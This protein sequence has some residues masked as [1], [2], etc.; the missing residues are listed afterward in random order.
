MRRIA[1]SIEDKHVEILQQRER[2]FGYG[3]E[4]GEVSRVAKTEAE[5]GDIAMNERDGCDCRSEQMNW[6][7]DEIGL[8]QR[9]GAELWFAVKNV[10][11]R[12]A[13]DLESFLAGKNRQRRSL[14][15]VERTNIVEPENVV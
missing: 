7:V 5:N 6:T 4:I 15:H 13:Q 10:G 1:K 14:P 12:A 11:E 9:H 2:R 8:D 3:A